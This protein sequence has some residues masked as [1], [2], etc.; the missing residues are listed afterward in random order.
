MTQ[1]EGDFSQ[2]IMGY[3]VL[4]QIFL[5]ATLEGIIRSNTT[6]FMS[7]DSNQ[8]FLKSFRDLKIINTIYIERTV[9]VSTTLV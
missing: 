3:N 1:R 7:Q 8:T 5:V 9:W 2:T 4:K 6:H